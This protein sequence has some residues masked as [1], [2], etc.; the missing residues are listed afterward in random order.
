M[1]SHFQKSILFDRAFAPAPSK[2]DSHFKEQLENFYGETESPYKGHDILSGT[3]QEN[4][5]LPEAD[6]PRICRF[7]NQFTILIS[8][9]KKTCEERQLADSSLLKNLDQFEE[10]FTSRHVFEEQTQDF[11]AEVKSTL[12]ILALRLADNSVS[13]DTKKSTM[14][15]LLSEIIACGSGIFTHIQI[16]AE[17]LANT[18]TIE[19][20]LAVY[21]KI[22]F[23]QTAQHDIAKKRIRGNS[24]HT[25][26]T[27]LYYARNVKWH[28][29]GEDSLSA[30]KET[31]YRY[32]GVDADDIV[33]FHHNY[34][35][36]LNH[37]SEMMTYLAE[38]IHHR[39]GE[40]IK[41][42]SK[43]NTLIEALNEQ[44]LSILFNEIPII[45]EDGW[46]NTLFDITKEKDL[47][48]QNN[49]FPIKMDS[50]YLSPKSSRDL[51]LSLTKH[52]INTDK[53]L[54][55]THVINQNNDEQFGFVPKAPDLC[56]FYSKEENKIQPINDRL[57]PIDLN[58]CR[59][60]KV[61]INQKTLKK[62]LR[63]NEKDF[64]HCLF[65]NIDFTQIDLE[66][67]DITH[68]KFNNA[69]LTPNQFITLFNKKNKI[70]K[71]KYKPDDITRC[72][73]E[74]D[75]KTPSEKAILLFYAVSIQ[76]T[77][78]IKHLLKSGVDTNFLN[79]KQETALEYAIRLGYW[80]VAK[81]FNPKYYYLGTHHYPLHCASYNNHPKI[82][83]GLLNAGYYPGKKI[84]NSNL[85]PIQCAAKYKNWT[86]VKAFAE[87]KSDPH[88][89][90]KY[91]S[92]LLDAVYHNQIDVVEALIKAQA[93][94]NYRYKYTQDYVLHCAVKN[95]NI[96]MLR[97]L[98][99][100]GADT[101]CV[102][103]QGQTP[104]QLAAA[105]G[106]WDCVNVIVEERQDP[107]DESKFGSA[108]LRAVS[109]N[110]I[111]T[112]KKIINAKAIINYRFLD[113]KNHVLHCAAYNNNP[114]M[115]KILQDAGADPNQTNAQD[116][117]PIQIA[118]ENGHWRCIK[119]LKQTPMSASYLIINKHLELYNKTVNQRIGQRQSQ[120]RRDSINRVRS[121]MATLKMKTEN[122][123]EADQ[124]VEFLKSDLELTEGHHK[125]G[126]FSWFTESNL[127]NSYKNAI[128]EIQECTLHMRHTP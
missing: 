29:P 104:I 116:K 23:I 67:L 21:R 106:Y 24:M 64:N 90:F 123:A 49:N 66:S 47:D 6:I 100:A 39:L 79:R 113:T 92:A 25:L 17:T 14:N 18:K 80:D 16:A 19:A 96:P 3:L 63:N 27:Y 2:L 28:L 72:I 5:I 68:A 36:R 58:T 121:Y 109:A 44:Y 26:N 101:T 82:I 46:I 88:D 120:E 74:L 10:N 8:K 65:D 111:E 126:W 108:L 52:F 1:S 117:T 34:L 95:N 50:Y 51:K 103:S 45:G 22:L 102:N 56:Y 75:S 31:Y 83:K 7:N 119:T 71:L 73:K 107:Y 37:T 118:I 61:P 78:L 70:S 55:H 69:R 89:N 9:L 32:A 93:T 30:L 12:E 115:I 84:N 60:W 85:T 98:L 125:Q 54:F 62:F 40:R 41:D 99:K 86:S 57:L 38:T 114:D 77:L 53:P 11:Y 112:V 76:S 33:A 128:R 81:A 4:D 13:H 124:F 91:G 97:L 127:A 48:P 87:T 42:F 105:K 110:K 20:C 59:E 15:N 35:N 122:Y 94:L 43:N